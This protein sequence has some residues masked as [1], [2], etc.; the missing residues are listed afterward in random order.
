MLRHPEMNVKHTELVPFGS[1]V[2][3]RLN[4]EGETKWT[5]GRSGVV[6]GYYKHQDLSLDGSLLVVDELALLMSLSSHS[7]PPVP[8]RTK[9]AKGEFPYVFPVA[10]YTERCKALVLSG[11][12]RLPKQIVHA[13]RLF[14]QDEALAVEDDYDES[15]FVVQPFVNNA[16]VYAVITNLI[17]R[18]LCTFTL[19]SNCCWLN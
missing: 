5:K 9:D 11:S 7:P 4:S 15:C 2:W 1:R 14:D 8:F 13:F 12:E 19:I 16:D 10:L 17:G 18:L 3:F 6:L